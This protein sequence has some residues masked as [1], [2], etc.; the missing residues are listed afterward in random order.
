LE[1]RTCQ[2]KLTEEFRVSVK[3]PTKIGEVFGSNSSLDSGYPVLP[4]ALQANVGI[5]ARLG[6][7]CFLP[8]IFQ[9]IIHP[10]FYHQDLCNL[11]SESV[12]FGQHG[13][14]MELTPV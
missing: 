10:S 1:E 11:A 5:V 12:V 9:F 6:H 7:D 4:P 8:D 2:H 3:L 14:N 13:S